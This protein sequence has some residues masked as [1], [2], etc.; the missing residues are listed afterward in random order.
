M[1]LYESSTCNRATI[2]TQNFEAF[3]NSY[4]GRVIVAAWPDI[5]SNEEIG[6]YTVRIP[7][8]VLIRKQ[9]W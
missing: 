9:K 8:K 6:Q 5:I 7:A 3:I 2:V 4:V 1:L